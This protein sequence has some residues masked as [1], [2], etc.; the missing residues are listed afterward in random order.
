MAINNKTVLAE[1]RLNTKIT[2]VRQP[3]EQLDRVLPE[4]Y[5]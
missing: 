2:T 1:L 4:I 3:E 5:Y